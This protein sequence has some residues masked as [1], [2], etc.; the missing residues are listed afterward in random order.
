VVNY[1]FLHVDKKDIPCVF[2]REG[3]TCKKGDKCDWKH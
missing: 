2:L 1:Q 3:G